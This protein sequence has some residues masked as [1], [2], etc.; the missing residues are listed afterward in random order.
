MSEFKCACPEGVDARTC[1]DLRNYGRSP[2]RRGPTAHADPMDYIEGTVP[3]F[4]DDGICEC[5]CHYDYEE[6]ES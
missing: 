4:D 1:Y 2:V 6:D 5:S 3:D